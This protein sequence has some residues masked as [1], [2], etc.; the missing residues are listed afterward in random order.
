LEADIL[1]GFLQVRLSWHTKTHAGKT[2]Q[3]VSFQMAFTK[4]KELKIVMI[5]TKKIGTYL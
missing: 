5:Y 4:E 3:T 2:T 1:I